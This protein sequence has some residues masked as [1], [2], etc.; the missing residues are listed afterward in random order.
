MVFATRTFFYPNFFLQ[1]EMISIIHNPTS[2]RWWTH[3]LD[4]TRINKNI[5]IYINSFF[6][7]HLLTTFLNYSIAKQLMIWA[8][9]HTVIIYSCPHTVIVLCFE[10]RGNWEL[11][12][13]DGGTDNWSH[14]MWCIMW[15]L[16]WDIF[17]LFRRYTASGAVGSEPSLICLPFFLFTH[18]LLFQH[19]Q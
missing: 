6:F 10:M 12:G 15:T 13:L 16:F 14:R 7:I 17:M 8:A 11:H 9:A 3:C 5:Y 1:F 2:K 4:Y 18:T 19:F